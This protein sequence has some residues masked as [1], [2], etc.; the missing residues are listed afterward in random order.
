MLNYFLIFFAKILEVTL[1]TLRTV[2]MT[3][4]ERV[5]THNGRSQTPLP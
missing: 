2:L 5:Y 4:G 1:M 3:R